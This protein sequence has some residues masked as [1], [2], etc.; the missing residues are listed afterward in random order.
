MTQAPTKDRQVNGLREARDGV[1]VLRFQ[2]SANQKDHENG[3]QRDGKDGGKG[4]SKGYVEAFW[5]SR[6]QR[7]TLPTEVPNLRATGAGFTSVRNRVRIVSMIA[8]A[9]GRPIVKKLCT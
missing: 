4:D 9:H 1:C 2:P 8:L 5:Y 7:W 6:M 3:N